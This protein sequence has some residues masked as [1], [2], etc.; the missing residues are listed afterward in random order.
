MKIYLINGGVNGSTGYITQSILKYAKKNGHSVRLAT[1]VA[2]PINLDIDYYHIGTSRGRRISSIFSHINGSDGFHNKSATRKLIKDIKKFKPD[3]LNLHTLHGYFINIPLLLTFLNKA[4]I[5]TIITMHDCW[6]ITGRC[7]HFT[8]VGCDMWTSGCLK[9]KFK[10]AYPSTKIFDSASRHFKLKKKLLNEFNDLTITCVSN[11][12]ASL[13]KQSPITHDKEILV[14]YNGVDEILFNI[15]NKKKVYDFCFVSNSWTDGKG[16]EM[17]LEIIKKAKNYTYVVVG[18]VDKK[19]VFPS[20]V[21][22]INVKLQ[23]N[24]LA[25]IYNISRFVI[26]VSKVETFS[27]INIEAQLCGT[28]IICYGETG[29][30]ET[31]DPL[32][33]FI[34]EEYNVFSFIKKMDEANKTRSNPLLVRTFAL[35]FSKDIMNRSYL[36]L[37]TR[38]KE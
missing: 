20:Y 2:K 32:N 15:L 14:L 22:H 29:M 8:D 4:N 17:L 6:W 24:D 30:K 36:D 5:K 27:L 18:R 9:C 37:Y 28:P 1:P 11:W 33:S 26:N 12:L 7:A 31:I 13:A 23:P 35:N 16:L 34:V 25:Q 10:Y 38:K 19:I 3:V 21:E